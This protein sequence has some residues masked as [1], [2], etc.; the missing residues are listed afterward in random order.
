M[1]KI[2]DVDNEKQLGFDKISLAKIIVPA[3]KCTLFTWPNK[4]HWVRNDPR[5]R[6]RMRT[7]TSISP[8][9]T[10]A[11]QSVADMPSMR[12]PTDWAVPR[13]SLTVPLS[14][15]AIERGRR[16]RAI[17]TIW[18]NGTLPECLMF[19]VF[20]RS[21]GGSLRALIT[22]DEA[23]G[24]MAILATRFWTMSSTVRR[25]PFQSA[26]CLAI[27]SPTFLGFCRGKCVR[28]DAQKQREPRTRPRGPI[29]GAR[30]EPP[31]TSP[32]VTRTLTKTCRH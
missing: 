17:S 4:Q 28:K 19:L 22:S 26:V 13:I 11:R 2:C 14:S 25:R 16:V 9:D 6:E 30:A 23:E 3:A 5:Q 8:L 1:T 24:T 21:R 32:P 10:L 7:G 12:Q 27:S 31:G 15:L 18:L 29:L 20:L